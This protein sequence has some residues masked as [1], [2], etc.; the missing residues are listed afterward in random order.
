MLFAASPAPS[1]SN[2]PVLDGL[3]VLVVD[4][5]A[6]Q[7]GLLTAILRRL[8]LEVIAVPSAEAALELCASPEGRD[9]RLIF[10]GWRMAG[11][12]G[13]GFCRAFR[14][15]DRG[16]DGCFILMTSETDRNAKAEG[17]EAGADD[18]LARPIDL[19]ELRARVRSA[20]RQLTMQS[21]LRDRAEALERVNAKLQSIHDAMA[22]DLREARHLQA[23]LIPDGA[24]RQGNAVVAS[25]LLA[26]NQV[27]GDLVGY[28]PLPHQ[29]IALYSIDVSGH[30]IASALLTGR[31]SGLFSRRSRRRNV[32]FRRDGSLIPP[33]EVMAGLNHF[34][35]KELTTDIYFTAVLAYVDLV[36]GEVRA[37]QAGHP[38]PLIR[39]AY[40]VVEP[41]G[42]GGPPVGLIDTAQF[43]EIRARLD[44]GDALLAHS[45]GLVDCEA[46][47]GTSLGEE[48]LAVILSS[49]P[50]DPERALLRIEG[51]LVDY[52]A[53]GPFGDDISMVML[54]YEAA[55]DARRPD[56]TRG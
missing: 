51:R 39:R 9:I 16:G 7:R 5:S 31:L 24:T 15:L 2:I 45:D 22:Q 47:D 41:I 11:L 56:P 48:R 6:A 34:M 50:S 37:C 44:P 20:L 25:K 23:A 27:G 10:S 18:F 35:L 46:P 42:S 3:R 29:A 17:L 55:A 26:C 1:S 33:H 40:G 52:A 54:R 4:G 49:G 43:A 12:D 53:N 8:G 36:T 13:P 14:S 32:A 30:G 19:P 21:Q 38:H 28:F